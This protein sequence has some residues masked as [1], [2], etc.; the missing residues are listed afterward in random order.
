VIDTLI[1]IVEPTHDS[2][3]RALEAAASGA[4]LVICGPSDAN[5]LHVP[6][7]L[8]EALTPQ[9]I[10][11]GDLFLDGPV[12]T[13]NEPGP[14]KDRRARRDRGGRLERRDYAGRAR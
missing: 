2:I 1:A 3:R 12:P 11:L 14:R 10:D 8:R 4:T 7:T 9:P 5:A 6:K 13:W